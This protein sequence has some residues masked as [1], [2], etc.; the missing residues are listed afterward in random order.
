M[1]ICLS[2][3]RRPKGSRLFLASVGPGLGLGF[4][5]LPSNCNAW[6]FRR[7]GGTLDRRSLVSD[8][9]AALDAVPPALSRRDA[10]ASLASQYV[11][12]FRGA[13]DARH[14]LAGCRLAREDVRDAGGPHH[15]I[16]QGEVLPAPLC[17]AGA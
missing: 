15:A 17:Q 10:D 13:R 4:L 7:F 14:R 12:C 16:C 1:C 5:A 3:P 6:H 2:P 9:S 8:L 11:R